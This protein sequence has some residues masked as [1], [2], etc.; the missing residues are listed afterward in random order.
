[1]DGILKTHGQML[2]MTSN[3]PEKLDPALVDS[4][5]IHRKFE[6][7]LASKK[8]LIDLCQNV[9]QYK[10][11][12]EEVEKFAEYSISPAA[13]VSQFKRHKREPKVAVKMVVEE[14]ISV[15]RGESK[16]SSLRGIRL[17]P[18]TKKTV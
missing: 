9:I 1:M 13:I 10:P 7:K 8:Q 17:D 16:E 15:M 5:R 3:H 6:F 2:I 14:S 11:E 12:L 18:E 4:E